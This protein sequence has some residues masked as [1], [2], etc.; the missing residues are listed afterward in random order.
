MSKPRTEGKGKGA[1]QITQAIPQVR[2]GLQ[3][4]W[5]GQGPEQSVSNY[6]ASD[7]SFSQTLMRSSQRFLRF[8]FLDHI[9]VCVYNFSILEIETIKQFNH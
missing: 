1:A 7:P 9:E 3:S 5:L 8:E 2:A 6:L 4:Q